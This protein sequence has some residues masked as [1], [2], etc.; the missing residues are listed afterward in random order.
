M[1]TISEL[2]R[3]G[4]LV[5]GGEYL[6][7]EP[8]VYDALHHALHLAMHPH[9]PNHDCYTLTPVKFVKYDPCPA[10]AIIQVGTGQRMRCS[11]DDLFISAS[12]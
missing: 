6:L 7:R 1:E 4:I 11:R 9:A 8:R 2:L 5:C 12:S 10:F 3:P